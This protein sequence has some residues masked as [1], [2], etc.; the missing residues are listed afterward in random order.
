MDLPGALINELKHGHA[1]I[2]SNESHAGAKRFAAGKGWH[3]SF[4]D[5]K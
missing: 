2:D 1:V 5:L 3:G 4:K